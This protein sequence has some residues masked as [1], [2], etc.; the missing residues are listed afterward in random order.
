M[1]K[2]GME[3]RMLL[4]KGME[5]ILERLYMRG[6]DSNPSYTNQP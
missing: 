3:R 4:E 1:R 2:I 6:R 5:N